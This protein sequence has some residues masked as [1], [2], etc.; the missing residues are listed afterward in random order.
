MIKKR[1]R[2]NQKIRRPKPE[3][4]KLPFIEH[5]YELKHRLFHIVISVGVVA[6]LVYF[7]QQQVVKILLR[8]AEGQQFIYTSPGGG[9]DFLFKVCI[10]SG[11][12]VSTPIIIYELLSYVKPLIHEHVVRF[13]AIGSIISGFLAIAGMVFG[14]FVGLPAVL[15]FLLHQF[16]TQQIRPLVT[17]QS[18][19]SFVMVYMVG[20]ALLFQIPLI[21]IFI[22]KI[23]PLKPRELFKYEKFIIAGSI[24]VAA[25]MNP[26]P[27]LLSQLIVAGPMVLMYQL[28]I[29]I[30][31][32]L[33]RG[34]KR[35]AHVMKL[36]EQDA[37]IQASRFSRTVRPYETRDT[38]PV[39]PA[40]TEQS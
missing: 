27:N 14:Y 8:P 29:G 40:Q 19:M 11:I 23:R 28:G 33:N 9:I 18:Y 7:V 25:L 35:P 36:I 13:I 22:N 38:E 12:A 34:Y 4:V 31:W 26:T 17:I 37:E 16:V 32:F 20:S 1:R 6:F 5:F 2:T 30:I 15:Q 21:L 24:V 39:P 3:D 10:Y